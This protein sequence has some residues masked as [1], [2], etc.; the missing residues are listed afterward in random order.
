MRRCL[1]RG[2]GIALCPVRTVADDLAAG[3]LVRL[4]WPHAPEET[5]ILMLTHSEKWRS[6]LLERFMAMAGEAIMQEGTQ[7]GSEL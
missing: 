7:R 2:V 3:R 4:D 1:R 6:P 5:M